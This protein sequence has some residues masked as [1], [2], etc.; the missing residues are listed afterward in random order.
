[1][2]PGL[3]PQPFVARAGNTS[4]YADI[5]G[6]FFREIR[7]TSKQQLQVTG[8]HHILRNYRIIVIFKK[9]KKNHRDRNRSH[10]QIRKGLTHPQG[11]SALLMCSKTIL[12]QL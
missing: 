10:N 2:T 7:I 1:M 3:V 9:K 8:K 12:D 6:H 5:Q 11:C 4:D